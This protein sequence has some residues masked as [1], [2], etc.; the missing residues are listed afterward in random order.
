MDAMAANL[1][2]SF[3]GTSNAFLA[4][5]HDLEAI[6]TNAHEIPMVVAALANDDAELRAS[7]Y[8]VLDLWQ[9]TYEGALRVMLPDTFGTTQ[10]LA[11][12]PDWVADWT[13]QRIDSKDPFV[14]GDEYISWLQSRGRDPRRKRLIA[15][16]ALD[17][18]SAPPA[19]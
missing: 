15:S 2:R 4:H 6:G 3:I 10:F 1:G 8:K 19:A 16:D 11:N 17:G 12:A 13:G 5:K 7:Q 9:Q 14:A 18:L